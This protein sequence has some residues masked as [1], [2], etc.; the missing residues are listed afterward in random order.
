[1]TT[2]PPRPTVV[3]DALDDT[4]AHLVQRASVGD[5]EAFGELYDATA[6]P[7][8]GLA[9]NVLG[10]ADLACEVVRDAFAEV[11]AYAPSWT[12]A[13][14]PVAAWIV[15][16][17]H[18]LAV[19]HVRTHGTALPAGPSNAAPVLDG[20]D[21]ADQHTVRLAYF[22]GRTVSQVAHSTGTSDVVVAG[23]LGSALRA[24]RDAARRDDVA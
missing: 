11:W 19:A 14:G 12:P 16:T 8:Y 24:I 18:R 10:D 1:M 3:P 20:L 13:H 15:A 21:L 23:R 4:L 5:L 6:G 2:T 17:T 22:G 9:L 7:V